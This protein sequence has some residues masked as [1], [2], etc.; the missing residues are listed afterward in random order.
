MYIYFSASLSENGSTFAGTSA[1]DYSV[2]EIDLTGYVV[3]RLGS[4]YGVDGSANAYDEC[5]GYWIQSEE[6]SY[7]Q[8]PGAPA[9][10]LASIDA[11]N[12]HT[13]P[14]LRIR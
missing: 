3:N 6:A 4:T 11:T 9:L 10:S 8:V 1:S 5:Q 14:S 2:V 12:P 7:Y 13:R